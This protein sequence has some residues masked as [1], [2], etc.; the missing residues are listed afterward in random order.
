[1]ASEKELVDR[2]AELDKLKQAHENRIRTTR[3]NKSNPAFFDTQIERE[4]QTIARAKQ[5]VERLI[6]SRDHAD[7]I[8]ADETSALQR[9]AREI[10]ILK[11]QREIDQLLRLQRQIEELSADVSACEVQLYFGE[12]K[13]RQCGKPATGTLH[14]DGKTLCACPDCIEA[15]GRAPSTFNLRGKAIS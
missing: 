8:I 1:M 12:H 13:W 4:M 3:T 2:I 14:I 6:Y 11:H 9:I 7:D 5:A 10:K 15:Y